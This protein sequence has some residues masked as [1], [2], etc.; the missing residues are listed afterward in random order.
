MKPRLCTFRGPLTLAC[1]LIALI[2]PL[3]AEDSSTKSD[4]PRSGLVVPATLRV[5]EA[6]SR[7]TPSG[8]EDLRAM[9]QH[10]RLLG[11]K[12]PA[13]TVAVQIGNSQGS[14]VIISPQG[15]ILTCAHVIGRP[16]RR[17]SIILSDGKRRQGETLGAVTI[18]D[19]G[20]IRITDPAPTGGWPYAAMA[21]YSSIKLGDWCL[22]TGH[23][24]GYRADR[25]SVVR[26]GRVIFRNPR[27]LQ[28]DC[29][30]V[31]GDSGG[32]LFDMH[33][34]VIAINSKIQDDP[35]AN[36]HVP[37]SVYQG[38]RKYMAEGQVLN[39]FDPVLGVWG[40][41]IEGGLKVTKVF[42]GDPAEAAGLRVGD[43]IVTFNSR[44]VNTPER[45]ADLVSEEIP[46]VEVFLEILRDGKPMEMSVELGLR[47]S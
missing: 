30:L 21:K 1:L 24:G 35:T 13:C 17:C 43:V 46:G 23:P 44:P 8:L 27:I 38:G 20:M 42:P 14:G 11:E 26:L 29:E 7:A 5:P 15:D 3:S 31:G 34:R 39:S 47:K 41:R 6:F 16:G 32:P 12:L 4:A 22:A 33:G 40:E 2:G 25:P 10:V 45:L 36:Y 19:G 18:L 28:S 9:E 37:I